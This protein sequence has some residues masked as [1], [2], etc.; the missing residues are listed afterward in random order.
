M[1]ELDQI[2]HLYAAAKRPLWTRVLCAWAECFVAGQL[3]LVFSGGERCSIIGKEPGPAVT[4]D[5]HRRRM[6][7]RLIS[8]GGLGFAEAYM[9]GEWSTSDLVGL[10]ELGIRTKSRFGSFLKLCARLG[11]VGRPSRRLHANTRAA[12]AANIAYHYDLGND[13]YSAW[14]DPTMTYSSALFTRPDLALCDAQREKY[15]RIAEVLQIGPSDRVLEIG[16]G[17]GGFSEYAAREIGCHVTGITLS[18]EQA[19]YARERLR[20]EGLD[21]RT[22]I[23]LQDYRDAEGSYDKIVSIEMFEAVGEEHWPLFFEVLRERLAPGGVAALQIITIADASFQAYRRRIDFIQ[24]YIFPGGMLPSPTALASDIDNAGL[25]LKN[26]RYFG[27]SYAATLAHWNAR[28]QSRWHDIAQLGFDER[29]RRMWTYYLA[30][31][32]ACFRLGQIDVGQFV[33]A[34]M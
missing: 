9:D 12:A 19:D 10:M 24:R 4:I 34:R 8:R 1:T 2:D 25:K 7:W 22:D 13:F 29:F 5:I 32:E 18:R 21:E 30:C 27:A 33:I 23:R 31:S 17:W 20:R 14:L 26:R 6:F 3:T 15:R 11:R 28:F 16:C